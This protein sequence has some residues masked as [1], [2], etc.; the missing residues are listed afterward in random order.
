[1]LLVLFI[2]LRPLC[3]ISGLCPNSTGT[4]LSL[5]QLGNCAM[6]IDTTY[7]EKGVHMVFLAPLA[8]IGSKMEMLIILVSAND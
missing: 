6:K 7:K 5:N 4:L 3:Y 8:L 1:M 2:V